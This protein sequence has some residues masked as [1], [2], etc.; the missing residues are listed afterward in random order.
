MIVKA[1]FM[2]WQQVEQMLKAQL[3]TETQREPG[4]LDSEIVLQETGLFIAISDNAPPREKA[5]K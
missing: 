1:Q 3:A 5:A 2:S 4:T